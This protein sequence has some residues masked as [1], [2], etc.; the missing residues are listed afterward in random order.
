[1]RGDAFEAMTESNPFQSA[2]LPKP[3]AIGMHALY[4]VS[5]EPP[6]EPSTVPVVSVDAVRLCDDTEA[7]ADTEEGPPGIKGDM[8]P[9]V[10]P[11]GRDRWG[12]PPL[13][14]V[15]RAVLPMSTWANGVWWVVG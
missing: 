10:W 12:D 2:I 11:G 3:R 5:W 9:C 13:D 14:I 4:E 1:M 6:S 15:D 7:E 8:W